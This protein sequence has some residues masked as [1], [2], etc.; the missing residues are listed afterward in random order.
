MDKLLLAKTIFRKIRLRHS[1]GD[2][3]KKAAPIS[4]SRSVRDFVPKR[5]H[6]G[7]DSMVAT[8][9]ERELVAKRKA[10]RD[11]LRLSPREGLY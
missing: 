10:T 2:A 8:Y 4:G 1:A 6:T 3:I 11:H 5:R 7:S 9:G